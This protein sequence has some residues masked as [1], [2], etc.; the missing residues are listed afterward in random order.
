MNRA[1]KKLLLLLRMGNVTQA[2]HLCKFCLPS[3]LHVVRLFEPPPVL[4][5][6]DV[7]G[8]PLRVNCSAPKLVRRTMFNRRSMFHPLS[9]RRVAAWLEDRKVLSLYPGRATRQINAWNWNKQGNVHYLS[10]SRPQRLRPSSGIEPGVI[11]LSVINVS[12]YQLS[13]NAAH[14]V[15][16][17]R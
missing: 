4:L 2:Y 15:K 12:L 1:K 6:L 5:S 14:E 11:N 7:L 13:S 10:F 16:H 9:G 3:L 8:S 17:Y